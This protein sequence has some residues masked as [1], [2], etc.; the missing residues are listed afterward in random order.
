MGGQR[1]EDERDGAGVGLD[2]ADAVR[3]ER[4]AGAGAGVTAG[5]GARTAARA[6]DGGG[7]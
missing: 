6:G 2:E 1:A 5:V 7:S 4:F 3:G